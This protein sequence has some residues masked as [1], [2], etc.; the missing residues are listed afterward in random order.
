[1]KFADL[2]ARLNKQF[3]GSN[4]DYLNTYAGKMQLL[5]TAANEAQ[6]KIGGA[7]IQSLMK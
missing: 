4:A 1:M 3:K 2:M 6:E 7:L 5:S